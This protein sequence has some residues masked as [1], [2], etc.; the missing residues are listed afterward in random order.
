MKFKL[1][2]LSEVWKD[3]KIYGVGLLAAL[4]LVV[5]SVFTYQNVIKPISSTFAISEVKATGD[6]D[7]NKTDMSYSF[8][9]MTTWLSAYYNAA[10]SPT[11][12]K[13]LEEKPGHDYDYH[14]LLTESAIKG[15]KAETGK[16]EWTYADYTWVNSSN[17]KIG[18]GGALL[19]FPDKSVIKGGGILG[20]LSSQTSSSTVDY[21]YDSLGSGNTYNSL[22]TYAYYGAALDALGIDSS[23]TSVMSFHPIRMFAGAVV[24]LGYI[25]A[26]G[27]ELLFKL[28]ISILQ[29]TNPF[30]WFAKGFNYTWTNADEKG[31]FSAL[32]NTVSGLYKL[33]AEFGWTVM[34]PLTIAIWIFM[35]IFTGN[36]RQ[37]QTLTKSKAEKFRYFI[38]YFLFLAVGVPVMG[39]AYTAGL[40]ALSETF[41]K[42]NVG[43]GGVGVDAIIYSAYIDNKA[44]IENNRLYLPSDVDLTWD[45]SISDVPY[46][47]KA[48]VRQY[49]LSINSLNHLDLKKATDNGSADNSW[50]LSNK[51]TGDSK[52]SEGV[53]TILL[54]YMLG[55]SY[56]P[57]DWETKVKSYLSE[58]AGR[59][60]S[61]DSKKPGSLVNRLN[62]SATE[63]TSKEGY[64]YI[65]YVNPHVQDGNPDSWGVE[66]NEGWFGLGKTY[67]FGQY[68]NIFL[69]RGYADEG[70]GG[71][72]ARNSSGAPGSSSKSDR[73]NF[74]SNPN[75]TV[76]QGMVYGN[77]KATMSYLEMFNYLN[78]KFTATKVRVYSTNTLTSNFSRESHAAVN[79]VGAGY[80]HKFMIWINTVTLL[81]GVAF[82]AVGYAV[83]MVVAS[84]K[85]YINLVTS[86]FLGT[87]GMQKG[88]VKAASATIMLIFEVVGTIV[89]YELAKTIYIA[90]PDILSNAISGLNNGSKVTSTSLT[91][92]GFSAG[93]ANMGGFV[94]VIF[95]L[96][97]SVIVLVWMLLMLLRLRKPIIDMADST[98]TTMI[99]KLFYAD[100]SLGHGDDTKGESGGM[101]NA[102][103]AVSGFVAGNSTSNIEGAEGDDNDGYVAGDESSTETN[104]GNGAEDEQGEKPDPNSKKA[105]SKETEGIGEKVKNEG[106]IDRNGQESA[107]ES[108]QPESANGEQPSSG[109]PSANESSSGSGSSNG[110]DSVSGAS[111]SS[112]SGEG[113][114]GTVISDDDTVNVSTAEGGSESGKGSSGKVSKSSGANGTKSS[115]SSGKNDEV[116]ASSESPKQTSSDVSSETDSPSELAERGLSEASKVSAS[117]DSG[118][119]S[120][121]DDSEQE[122]FGPSIATAEG[123][124][125]LS[126]SNGGLSS[127]ESGKQQSSNQTS[128]TPVS[129]SNGSL[130]PS[131]SG[132][133]Q[134]GNQT[135][136]GNAPS[137]KSNGGIAHGEIGKQQGSSET[138]KTPSSKSGN[139]PTVK[140][141]G[142]LTASE[143]GKQQT[144]NQ[145]GKT[146]TTKSNSV[147]TASESGKQ[148]SSS[149][150]VSKASQH[151]EQAKQ[152]LSSAKDSVKQAGSSAVTASKQAVSGVRD[153][154]NGISGVV[155]GQQSISSGASQVASGAKQMVQSVS[156][157]GN[158][159]KNG[160]SRVSQS[161]SAISNATKSAAISVGSSAV[162]SQASRIGNSV[163]KGVTTAA[164]TQLGKTLI[165]TALDRS[166][167]PV[168][169]SGSTPQRQVSQ[170]TGS[171]GSS[172]QQTVLRQS[173]AGFG[174]NG[175]QTIVRNQSNTSND[176]RTSNSRN[177]SM[178]N[179]PNS[180][181]SIPRQNASGN[182]G[183]SLDR[184]QSGSGS[185][186]TNTSAPTSGIKRVA[187]TTGKVVKA[188]AKGMMA[189]GEK[190]DPVGKHIENELKKSIGD[191]APT[192]SASS[193][194]LDADFMERSHLAEMERLRRR[195]RTTRPR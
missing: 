134:G 73:L 35:F 184:P 128:K 55:E 137:V 6:D 112:G 75:A 13:T 45:T 171:T 116:S 117:S 41:N 130:T 27:A 180:S 66:V 78:S 142:G 135:G 195:N 4:G 101:T 96:M 1:Q 47:N 46:Q 86:I 169:S 24:W 63:L 100:G 111:S 183:Q 89:I 107:S 36:G 76:K 188:T 83:G 14:T 162:V 187:N 42:D 22:E 20:F 193:N 172:G 82:L 90:I 7:K 19:G 91:N 192:S 95:S 59:G 194:G 56:L 32:T 81:F 69:S 115:G 121:G 34:I 150:P 54:R 174:S 88:M 37:N 123:G 149:S 118:K 181:G 189:T 64:R 132:K 21:S 136:N 38:V 173:S 72:I 154:A 160:A 2:S 70:N 65:A 109:A 102:I 79:Q 44:W 87:L 104:G 43:N 48:K 176:N 105:N 143:S 49:A 145:S 185:T 53:N 77:T 61:D 67:R 15:A 28:A 84:F 99:G 127:G 16:N 25:I 110:S 80:V 170:S 124:Q 108:E 98:F 138:G 62:A 120:S 144:S 175:G 31:M 182:G 153:V 71:F 51:Q 179:R 177:T 113:E 10:S 151:M 18:G 140:S 52:T 165:D 33:F 125:G 129:K 157:A 9:E 11:G 167:S 163:A 191:M 50:N 30:N 17:K 168:S 85:R 60:D 23:M 39:T 146:P 3:T 5:G 155:S 93:A 97:L 126:K 152:N 190:L 114:Q 164:N 119:Q 29:V 148:Q 156:S 103:S 68:P 166:S 161:A 40:D 131:E 92:I 106:G 186:G 8:Y 147:L 158:V 57:S 139:A 159:I 58:A 26:S 133:Q 94:L 12:Y 178:T 74:E 122:V 141:N